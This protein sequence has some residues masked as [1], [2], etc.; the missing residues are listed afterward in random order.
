MNHINL[1]YLISKKITVKRWLILQL[2]YQKESEQLRTLLQDQSSHFNWFEENGF[3]KFVKTPKDKFKSV[4][5]GKK[6]KELLSK[7][8]IMNNSEEIEELC[9]TLIEEYESMNKPTGTRLNV[10]DNLIWFI[11]KTDFP[12]S[13]IED[14]ITTYLHN[15]GEFTKRL[16]NLIWTPASKAFSVHK[17]L[18]DSMLYDILIK[19]L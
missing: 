6:G 16:D 5:I 18:K 2:V 11:S 13:D 7:S 12:L 9:S 19:E 10:L 14:S 15:S 8:S 17:N 3:I 1:T 4:R